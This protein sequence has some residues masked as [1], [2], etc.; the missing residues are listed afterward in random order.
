VNIWDG[1]AEAAIEA[2]ARA[3]RHS[4]LDPF[5]FGMQ[6]GTAFGHFLAG[7]YDEA[8]SWAEKSLRV[9]QNRPSGL[10]LMAA[11]YALAGRLEEAQSAMTRARHLDAELRVSS[12]KHWIRFRRPE[13]LEKYEQALRIAGLPE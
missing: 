1:E 10:R 4:P 11:S 2:F 13:H 7:R 12:V 6:Q 3:M 9:H 5:S 8:S